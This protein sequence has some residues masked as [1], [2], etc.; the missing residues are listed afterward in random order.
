MPSGRRHHIIRS[1]SLKPLDE[2]HVELYP[3][4]HVHAFGTGPF[5]GGQKKLKNVYVD[6]KIKYDDL[7]V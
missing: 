7:N 4:L 6:S 5:I 2:T 1:F 3:E